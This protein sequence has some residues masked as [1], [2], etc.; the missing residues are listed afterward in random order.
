M[1]AKIILQITYVSFCNINVDKILINANDSLV[2]TTRVISTTI[3]FDLDDILFI[4][5]PS[6]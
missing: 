6:S 2:Y 4:Q 3:L 5:Y 1:T